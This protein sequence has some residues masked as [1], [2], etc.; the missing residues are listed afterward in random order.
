VNYLKISNINLLISGQ[1]LRKNCLSSFWGGFINIQR[2]LPSVYSTTT[3]FSHSWNPEYSALVCHVYGE[4][5]WQSEKQ[6][7]Y[8]YD[9][10]C[11]LENADSFEEGATR[12][13]STWANISFQ[14]V[15][16]NI[17][18]RSNV[19][20]NYQPNGDYC[21]FLR[22]DF[23]LSGE[24][25]VNVMSFDPLLPADYLYLA[26]FA[27]SDE[28]YAD[29][30]VGVPGEDVYKFAEL[31]DFA[32]KCLTV[33]NDFYELMTSKGWP[34]S[35]QV[36]A[37]LS[38]IQK[39]IQRAKNNLLSPKVLHFLDNVRVNASDGLISRIMRRMSRKLIR[40]LNLPKIQAEYYAI[41][42][43]SEATFSKIQSLNI[44]SIFKLFCFRTG[45]RSKVRF[46]RPDDTN[47]IKRGKLINSR[48]NEIEASDLSALCIDDYTLNAIAHW[49]TY[50]K[51]SVIYLVDDVSKNDIELDFPG[52]YY[53]S[54]SNNDVKSMIFNKAFSKRSQLEIAGVVTSNIKVYKYVQV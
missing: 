49:M 4:H 21:L 43:V 13:G 17:E 11:S 32:V 18:S 12:V 46:C 3:V 51:V 50:E 25:P 38:L 24:Y 54:L 22:W 34:K 41:N 53:G 8:G 20:K 23:G 2:Q 29:M 31:F 5:D 36:N 6:P 14:N 26:D 52:L 27:H 40:R 9:I 15:L 28:G 39:T 42:S 7:E 19:A 45:L 10:L 44:H 35:F 47:E 30:W 33:K 1:I 37:D 16:G 48:L